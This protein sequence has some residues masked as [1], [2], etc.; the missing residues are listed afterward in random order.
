MGE[1]ALKKA[2]KKDKL[3][4]N[5]WPALNMSLEL[6]DVVGEQKSGSGSA[7][8]GQVRG[9]KY[10][11][12]SPRVSGF[13]VLLFGVGLGSGIKMSEIFPSGFRFSGP[14]LH[15]YLSSNN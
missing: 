8:R 2:S 14:R 3:P 9:S 5:E 10:R 13:R 7:F 4:V 1:N 15:H 11:G 6:S 12:F